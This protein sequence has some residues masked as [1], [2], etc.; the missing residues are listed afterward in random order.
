MNNKNIQRNIFVVFTEADYN[1]WLRKYK[2]KIKQ[3]QISGEGASKFRSFCGN[4]IIEYTQMM[5]LE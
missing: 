2:I 4:V 3:V 5:Y 1:S